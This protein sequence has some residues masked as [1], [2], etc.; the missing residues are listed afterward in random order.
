MSK[1]SDNTSLPQQNDGKPDC[2]REGLIILARMIARFITNKRSLAKDEADFR[3][4]NNTPADIK[5]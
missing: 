2:H 3:E 5:G 4:D 1:Q